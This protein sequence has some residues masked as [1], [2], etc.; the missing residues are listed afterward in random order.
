MTEHLPMRFFIPALAVTLAALCPSFVRGEQE[1]KPA[2][3]VYRFGPW[4]CGEFC[5]P[6][7]EVDLHRHVDPA[8]IIG[9]W[10]PITAFAALIIR[11]FP[12]QGGYVLPPH[13]IASRI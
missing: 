6:F 8:L 10:T 9:F 2:I 1:S 12:G 3:P 13:L 5:S 11:C 4:P 7:V